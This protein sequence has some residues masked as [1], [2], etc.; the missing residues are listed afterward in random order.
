MGNDFFLMGK[1]VFECRNKEE[2]IWYA[3]LLNQFYNK[4]HFFPDELDV[5]DIEEDNELIEGIFATVTEDS[6]TDAAYLTIRTNGN[7]DYVNE[8]TLIF[9]LYFLSKQLKMI[10][11]NI[12]VENISYWDFQFFLESDKPGKI[13]FIKYEFDDIKT[14]KYNRFA[15]Y[16]LINNYYEIKKM[17]KVIIDYPEI[18]AYVNDAVK[19]KADDG[20]KNY[21]YYMVLNKILTLLF[22]RTDII[23]KLY[24]FNKGYTK[25]D[26]WKKEIENIDV[27]QVE[28]ENFILNDN[29]FDSFDTNYA[30]DLIKFQAI[31]HRLTNGLSDYTEKYEPICHT[32]DLIQ[33]DDLLSNEELCAKLFLNFDS[34]HS[35]INLNFAK[36]V[37]DSSLDDFYEE[38]YQPPKGQDAL[39]YF[40]GQGPIYLNQNDYE[41]FFVKLSGFTKDFYEYCQTMPKVYLKDN[42]YIPLNAYFITMFYNEF[43]GKMLVEQNPGVFHLGKKY[44]KEYNSYQSICDM[45]INKIRKVTTGCDTCYDYQLLKHYKK[46]AN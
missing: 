10:E 12:Y 45:C 43:K 8:T 24:K 13:H 39:S 1:A 27:K 21:K 19:I 25:Y 11:C 38:N 40:I 23:S 41:Y 4:N 7:V 46:R 26:D 37:H 18:N 14:V 30:S 31:L 35:L 44:N 42:I 20:D 9:P 15:I 29:S 34:N 28:I 6:D 36:K 32:F 16:D 5:F 33:N 2:A 17:K 3:L 22:E